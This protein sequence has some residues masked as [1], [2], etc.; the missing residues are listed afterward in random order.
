MPEDTV[1]K[2]K[3]MSQKDLEKH[4]GVKLTN[5]EFN[6]I[7]KFACEDNDVM[8]GDSYRFHPYDQYL[9]SIKQWGTK[10]GKVRKKAKYN[11]QHDLFDSVGAGSFRF[12]TADTIL[13]FSDR[14]LKN[15]Y[16]SIQEE[17]DNQYPKM[18]FKRE[19]VRVYNKRILKE[20]KSSSWGG[21]PDPDLIIGLVVLVFFTW[22]IFGVIF[23]GG[24]L[25][26]GGPKF[27]G[28]DGG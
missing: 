1:Y 16:I 5:E 10:S 6:V 15:I 21:G 28:H 8:V 26:P 13:T 19:D 23:G 9:L 18:E 25:S 2:T 7:K 20:N 12:E 17:I 14:N 24:D 22:L 4:Y 3:R 27:F 11:W